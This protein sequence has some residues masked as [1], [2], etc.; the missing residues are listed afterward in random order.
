MLTNTIFFIGLYLATPGQEWSALQQQQWEA[1]HEQTQR[2]VVL[3]IEDE[4]PAF[5]SANRLTSSRTVLEP[6]LRLLEP[7]KVERYFQ[8][9]YVE[10]Q[11]LRNRGLVLGASPPAAD[12]NLY[13][14]VRVSTPEIAQELA[15][16]LKAMNGVSTAYVQPGPAPPP[17]DIPPT[18]PDWTSSQDY[19]ESPLDGTNMFQVAGVLGARGRNIRVTDCEYD[20]V[21]DHEDLELDFS[22]Y[23]GGTPIGLFSDHG[24]AVFGQF[25]GQDNGYGVTGGVPNCDPYFATEYATTFGFDPTQAIINAAGASSAN[26]VILLEMQTFGP[27][28][29]FVPEEWTQASFDAIQNA[30]NAGIHVVEAGANGGQDLDDAIFNG[31]FDVNVRDSGAIIVGAGS[32]TQAQVKLSFT[33]RGSRVDCQGWGEAIYTA[34]YGWL[35]QAG[36]DDRQDYT[37]AFGGTSGAS[38]IVT[39]A[40]TSLLGA[41]QAHGMTMPTPI[42]VRDALRVTGSPQPAW[43]EATGRI[44][45]QPDM[46]E[47]FEWFGLP[48]GMRHAPT[49]DLGGMLNVDLEGNPNESWTL[50]R[51]FDTVVQSTVAGTR[52]LGNQQFG[53]IASGNLN[54]SGAATYSATV[55]NLPV[56]QNREV[57]L[58]ALFDAT[59][60]PRLSNGGAVLVR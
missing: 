21:Y 44:G 31:L 49:A 59:G 6:V 36:T 7:H 15:I 17:V 38:P 37:Q 4:I 60:T 46:E 19:F 20:Y 25:Y 26:D 18:T 41:M 47:L 53:V 22:R 3:K 28:N 55:P 5:V 1:A 9:S 32:S 2:T 29:A 14:K 27:N 39:S 48:T 52:V 51:A 58:Q 11:E 54:A 10:L 23:V 16:E 8:Q 35:F 40:V 57:F 12:L 43:D 30:T 56:L 13:F 45:P 24:T 33:S 42:Q 50:Y 34:G